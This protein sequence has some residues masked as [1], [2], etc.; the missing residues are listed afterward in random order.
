MLK[1][2]RR[3]NWIRSIH[4]SLAIEQNSLTVEQ[5]N[6]II[7]GKKVLGPLQ[8]IREVK[9]VY[10]AYELLIR[11]NPYS[12]KGLLKAHK[13]M[14][15]DFVKKAGIIYVVKEIEIASIGQVVYFS[16]MNLNLYIL[17]QAA[18]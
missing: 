16:F 6:D 10:E 8:D 5:V 11:L 12:V 4:S 7:V 3:E 1:Q 2:I 9:N 17:M 18:M 14:M 13:V 15:A